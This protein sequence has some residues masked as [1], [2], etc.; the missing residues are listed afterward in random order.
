MEHSFIAFGCTMSKPPPFAATG[1]LSGE[2][3]ALK[4]CE[5]LVALSLN[6]SL[7]C[8]DLAFAK[9]GITTKRSAEWL[10]QTAAHTAEQYFGPGHS[11]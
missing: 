8:A 2:S 5:R 9:L 3:I 6:S 4:Q 10:T 11:R 1:R 7:P